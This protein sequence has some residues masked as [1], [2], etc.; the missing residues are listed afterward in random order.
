MPNWKRKYIFSN[1][2]KRIPGDLKTQKC[3]GIS[4][5]SN[6]NVFLNPNCRVYSVIKFTL[7]LI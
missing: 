6:R 4:C 3:A 2:N 7:V 1:M 5:H